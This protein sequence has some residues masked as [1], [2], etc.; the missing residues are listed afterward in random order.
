ML[1][2]GLVMDS[3]NI[4]SWLISRWRIG[5]VI[6]SGL[7]VACIYRISTE[8]EEQ[9][10]QRAKQKRENELSR[11]AKQISNYAR[12]LHQRYPDGE[13]V[14]SDDDLSRQLHKSHEL[15]ATALAMLLEQKQV[16]RAPLAG[17]WKLNS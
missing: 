5:A 2:F 11:V 8:T 10:A 13:I 14:I 17:Y 6:A 16:Q 1:F 15:V 9:R 7:A 4:V 12:D 3:T